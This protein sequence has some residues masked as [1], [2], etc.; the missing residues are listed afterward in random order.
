MFIG[1]AHLSYV[2]MEF[3]WIR[4]STAFQRH[5]HEQLHKQLLV[6]DVYTTFYDALGLNVNNGKQFNKKN[7]TSPEGVHSSEWD[8]ALVQL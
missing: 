2:C 3:Q 6:A 7:Y 8:K 4:I 5:I 1:Q